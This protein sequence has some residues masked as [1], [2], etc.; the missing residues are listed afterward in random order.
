MGDDSSGAPSKKS[1]HIR[2]HFFRFFESTLDD[3]SIEKIKAGGL[4]A[5][6]RESGGGSWKTPKFRKKFPKNWGLGLGPPIL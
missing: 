1:S 3:L 6:F 4:Q 2:Y 5:R